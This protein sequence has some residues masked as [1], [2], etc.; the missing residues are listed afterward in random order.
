MGDITLELRVAV[1]NT[2]HLRN[3]LLV[4][5]PDRT[6]SIYGHYDLLQTFAA[7]FRQEDVVKTPVGRDEGVVGP[8]RLEKGSQRL[9]PVQF[10]IQDVLDDLDHTGGQ[11]ASLPGVLGRLGDAHLP[12]RSF[13]A[14]V[15]GLLLSSPILAPHGMVVKQ[16]AFRLFPRQVFI[17]ATLPY[18]GC[19]FR[20][21]P[22]FGQHFLKQD[23]IHRVCRHALKT[24]G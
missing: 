13:R 19:S 16:L 17:Q 18:R 5:T 21:V 12:G 3:E 8:G 22:V 1:D 20:I 10:G 6:G 23:T 24:A 2:D 7:E 11:Q 14:G 15:G 9:L 4:K